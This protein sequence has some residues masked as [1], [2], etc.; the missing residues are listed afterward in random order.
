MIRNGIDNA[1]ATGSE[2]FQPHLLGLLATVQLRSGSIAEGL[3]SVEEA[4]AVS[5]R[6]G[7]RFYAAELHRIRGELHWASDA[8][9]DRRSRAQHDLTEALAIARSQNASLPARRAAATLER[10]GAG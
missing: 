8:S 3:R 5:A 7:E 2:M 4:L 9:E 6:T 10:L 1:R